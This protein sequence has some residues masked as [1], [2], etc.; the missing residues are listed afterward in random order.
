MHAHS[1]QVAMVLTC[2]YTQ[3]CMCIHKR[4]MATDDLCDLPVIHCMQIAPP[5]VCVQD[6]L[7]AQTHLQKY[8][9]SGS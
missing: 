1:W 8:I 5:Q 2:S 4:T 7:Q 6:A 3:T 9:S